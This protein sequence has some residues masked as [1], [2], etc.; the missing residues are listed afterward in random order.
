MQCDQTYTCPPISHPGILQEEEVKEEQVQVQ[1]KE[2][3]QS[4]YAGEQLPPVPGVS[5][6]KRSRGEAEKELPRWGQ[7]LCKTWGPSEKILRGVSQNGQPN[8]GSAGG[9]V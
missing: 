3:R 7:C 6:S 8:S 5:V 4:R 1:R 9:E 2:I